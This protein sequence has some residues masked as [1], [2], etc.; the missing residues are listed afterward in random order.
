[1]G[2]AIDT[3]NAAAP[4]REVEPL[5]ASGPLTLGDLLQYLIYAR[6][7]GK[8]HP[9]TPVVLEDPK[10]MRPWDVRGVRLDG[11]GLVLDVWGD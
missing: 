7:H 4:P 6:I 11:E 8:V 9:G 5:H 1:M 2:Q 3:I 10:F